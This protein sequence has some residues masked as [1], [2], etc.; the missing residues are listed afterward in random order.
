MRAHF[1]NFVREVPTRALH[2]LHNERPEP[3]VPLHSH[4]VDNGAVPVEE[5]K[6][7]RAGR[8]P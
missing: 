8:K 6:K 4:V 5:L 3:V 2:G 7:H 1:K